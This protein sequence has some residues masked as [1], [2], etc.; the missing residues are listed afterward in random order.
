MNFSVGLVMAL[1]FAGQLTPEA[2]T[3]RENRGNLIPEGTVNFKRNS[4]RLNAEMKSKLEAVVD[5]LKQDASTMNLLIVGH[6][7]TKG[8]ESRS[9]QL[10]GRRAKAVQ[11]FLVKQGVDREMLFVDGVRSREP[12]AADDTPAEHERNQRVELWTTEQKPV[13]SV[14]WVLNNTQI[15]PAGAA[16]WAVSQIGTPVLRNFRMQTDES[17]GAEITFLKQTKIFVSPDSSAIAYDTRTLPGRPSRR[18]SDVFIEAGTVIVRKLSSAA[19]T[20]RI[21]TAGTMVDLNASHARIR[22][23]AQKKIT[24]VSIIDGSARVV[25]RGRTVKLASGEAARIVEKGV[26]VKSNTLTRTPIWVTRGPVL[27]HGST[28]TKIDWRPPGRTTTTIAEFT[29]PSDPAF[30][31]PI[32][33]MEM[34]GSSASLSGLPPGAY[35]LRLL[36]RSADGI[37]SAPSPGIKLIALAQPTTMSEV[38]VL[39]DK[40]IVRMPGPGILYQSAPDG[41]IVQLGDKDSQGPAGTLSLWA[42]GRYK[43]PYRLFFSDGETLFGGGSLTVNVAQPNIQLL[44]L[45]PEVTGEQSRTAVQMRILGEGEQ[46]ITGLKFKVFI[47]TDKI[48]NLEKLKRNVKGEQRGPLQPCKCEAPEGAA[49]MIEQGNGYYAYVYQRMA[50]QS[51][52]KDRLRIFEEQSK[53]IQEFEVPIGAYV[54]SAPEESLGGFITTLR[55]GVQLAHDFQPKFRADADLGYRLHLVGAL[56]MDLTAQAGVYSSQVDLLD[57][58]M[59]ANG[60]SSAVVLP[61]QGRAG[62]ALKFG[63]GGVYFGGGGGIGLVVSDLA[64]E[65]L[66]QHLKPMQML[67]SG[68]LGMS[69]QTGPGEFV[70]HA[71]YGPQALQGNA[72]AADLWPSITLGYRFAPWM[73]KSKSLD[74]GSFDL[75]DLN[76][77]D[78]DN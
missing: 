26:A 34:L 25:A 45:T 77:G 68:Y 61:V 23:D 46:P 10:S 16:E 4:S 56:S 41:M 13:G 9:S 51:F 36:S 73:S 63:N 17:S 39:V 76:V 49:D 18:T 11:A 43:V 7:D 48:K 35:L 5:R 20:L 8:A 3:A 14:T 59:V 32:Q 22:F 15:M 2:Q 69:Y 12:I 62:F 75:N 74:V 1:S 55:T 47:S 54:A 37:L 27:L 70:I 64:D 71:D 66:N 58:A 31:R 42:A 44:R 29:L 19:S 57:G 60:Q 30:E 65:A 24:T 53:V 50:G 38:P 40:S 52:R 72:V 6:T 28:E 33:T 21:D 67:W 78:V